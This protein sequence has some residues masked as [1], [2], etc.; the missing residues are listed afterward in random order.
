MAKHKQALNTTSPATT[1]A[2]TGTPIPA[3]VFGLVAVI[4]SAVALWPVLQNSYIS[5]DD[6]VYFYENEFLTRPLGTALSH[7]FSGSLYL[8]AYTP[9]TLSVITIVSK[10]AGNIEPVHF[11]TAAL[12]LHLINVFLVFLFTQRLSS[13]NTTI[14]FFCA[15]LFGIHPMHV[16]SVAWAAEFKDVLFT[17]FYLAGL[18]T[19]LRATDTQNKATMWLSATCLFFILSLL[20]KPA[21]VTFPIVLLL[22]Q[23][24]QS[25]TVT[26]NQS[27]L[28]GIM[29]ILSVIIGI[30]TIYGQSTYPH[31]Q[32]SHNLFQRFLVAAYAY[33]HYYVSLVWPT[34]MSIFYPYP[35]LVGGSMPGLYYLYLLPAAALLLAAWFFR[36]SAPYITF[37]ISFFTI[38]I[39]LV[40]QLFSPG[41]SAMADHYTYLSYLGLIFAVLMLINTLIQRATAVKVLPRIA[42][43]A[44][45]VVLIVF[46]TIANARVRHW[47]N[48]ETMANEL[49][50]QYPT[51]YV[52]LNNMGFVLH[53]QGQSA[54][55]IT[56]CMQAISQ[57][58]DY[59]YPYVNA[60]NAA[61]ALNDINFAAGLADSAARFVKP[62]PDILNSIGYV[63]LIQNRLDDAIV[64]YKKTI[65][66]Q[67]TN[68]N[69]YLALAEIYYRKKDYTTELE[70]L[71]KGL[72]HLP[73]NPILLNYKGYALYTT[74][75]YNEAILMYDKALSLAPDYKAA[76]ENR[77]TC[78][79][80][81]NVPR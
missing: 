65:A 1:K 31:M 63:A 55:A 51:N 10:L 79:K 76:S 14:A 42:I 46:G 73:N 8:G 5:W 61:I 17:A 48:D 58:K 12:V 41:M 15:A 70:I 59:P 39:L 78:L 23:W 4:A 72:Q 33:T 45:L 25:K 34:G 53:S 19:W 62:T 32:E 49:L 24:Y 28:I 60:I 35:A 69:A 9:V 54:P 71:N 22:M 40:L 74:G 7:F 6:N 11:H 52:A 68:R 50:G 3:F 64:S 57:K 81:M 30:V 27:I 67:P 13:G 18:I 36:N 56:Y 47:Q 29:V 66:M 21:A 44:G 43:G 16:E 2:D 37:G 77:T 20:S 26:R 75:R 38:N 80:A